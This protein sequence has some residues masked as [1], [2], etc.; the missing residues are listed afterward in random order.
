[1]EKLTDNS[2]VKGERT[3]AFDNSPSLSRRFKSLRGALNAAVGRIQPFV[4]FVTCFGV[5]CAYLVG[6]YVT[7]TMHSASR[8]MG[9]MLACTSVIVVLQKSGYRES[10]SVGWMRVFGTFLG[11]FI[12]YI[13]L[14]LLPFTVVGMLGTVFVLEMFMMVLNIYSTGY[15]A[16]MTL[17]IIMLVSQMTPDVDPLTNCMLRFFESAAGVGVGVAILWVIDRWR[18]WRKR[19]LRIGASTDGQPVDMDTMPLRWGH[20]RVVL[21][22][23]LGQITGAA[24]STLVGVLIPLIQIV[25]HPEL[26]PL[27]QGAL[28]A[29]TLVGIMVGSVFI[30]YLSDRYGYLL[31]FRLCPV[32]VLA[33]SLYA[34]ASDGPVRLL[35]ALF[36]M[37]LGVGGGYSLD[38]DYISE[39]M[40]RRWR[41]TMVGIAKAASAV[42]NILM[43]VA[44]YFIIRTWRDA[45]DWNGLLLLVSLLAVVMIVARIRFAQSPAW[46]F[47]HGRTAEAEQAVHYLLGSDVTIGDEH[48]HPQNRPASRLGWGGMF[49]RGNIRKLI[50]SGV[51]WACEGV[52]VYGIGIFLPVLILAMGLGTDSSSALGRVV[53]SVE[54]S[55]YVNLFVA[56]G[57][58]AGLFMLGRVNRIRMQSA[59]FVLCAAGLGLLL[60]AYL[61]HLPVWVAVAG[62]MMFELF[63]NAGPHLVT[64]IIPSQ[65]Y[66]VD[67]R[68]A[69]AGL[70]AAFGKAGAVLG[71]FFFPLLMRWGGVMAAISFTIAMQIAGAAVT[72]IFSRGLVRPQDSATAE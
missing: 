17:L 12:A 60:A 38:S 48:R 62:F 29:S 40:P 47:A 56:V 67:E 14:K 4:L 13:Y 25:V 15:I 51:P 18:A 9:A 58:A 37:G 34:F 50:F 42:G 26:P 6:M 49:R 57:F 52:G 10:L 64:F 3:P 46:L 54:T 31:F 11:A 71:V 35:F 36:F 44:C 1:M 21:V 45:G 24:I 55:I 65:I 66:S 19:L 70:A 69:G 2:S 72:M 33:A 7:G 39:I 28:A 43:A 5:L 8:W 61:L 59:G 68:G 30:G 20:L 22:A 23:S 27:M 32:L 63:I 16:T 53:Q 41:T